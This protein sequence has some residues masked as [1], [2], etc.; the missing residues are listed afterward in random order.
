MEVSSKATPTNIADGTSNFL[1]TKK[2][3]QR[4]SKLSKQIPPK[5]SAKRDRHSKIYTAKG[6]RD[7]RMRLS[8]EISRKFFDLQDLLGFDKASKTIAWLLTQSKTAVEELMTIGLLQTKNVSSASECEVVSGVYEN[9]SNLKPKGVVSKGKSSVG[10]PKEKKF[11]RSRKMAFNPL[12][13]D[14]REKAR[15]RARERTS[16][17]MLNRGLEKSRQFPETS[18]QNLEQFRSSIPFKTAEE[19]KHQRPTNEEL[20]AISSKFHPSSIFN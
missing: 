13:R 20:F 9:D 6:P 14:A 8:V 5:R 4:K 7:R 1:P 3:V 16:E 19:S 10:V 11:K 2:E 15:A 17:K 18:T 12:A